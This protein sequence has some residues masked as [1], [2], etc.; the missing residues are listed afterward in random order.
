MKN[1]DIRYNG[2]M[3]KKSSSFIFTTCAIYQE[4]HTKNQYSA[5]GLKKTFKS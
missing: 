2:C 1:R 3:E 4:N 5:S